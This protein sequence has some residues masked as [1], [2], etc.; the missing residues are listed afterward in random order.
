MLYHQNHVLL[1]YKSIKKYGIFG[2]WA[3]SASVCSVYPQPW[4]RTYYSFIYSYHTLCASREPYWPRH[5]TYTHTHTNIQKIERSSTVS[6]SINLEINLFL[7]VSIWVLSLIRQALNPPSN[8]MGS[9]S[10]TPVCT[11]CVYLIGFI[12]NNIKPRTIW[13]KV[14]KNHGIT[15]YTH[16]YTQRGVLHA[17]HQ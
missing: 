1:I 12:G 9:R 15:H 13:A 8:P 7:I 3:P 4:I 16:T 14:G 17:A 5:Q 6:R 2:L 11:G 10:H